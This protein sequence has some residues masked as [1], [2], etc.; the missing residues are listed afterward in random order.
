[1]PYLTKLE[2]VNHVLVALKANEELEEADIDRASNSE[3][4]AFIAV[5]YDKI[6]HKALN[7][8]HWRFATEV[9]DTTVLDDEMMERCQTVLQ[10]ND[11]N[12]GHHIGNVWLVEWY[13]KK[14][15]Y[16]KTGSPNLITIIKDENLWR[17]GINLDIRTV[18]N[19]NEIVK[20]NI[21]AVPQ[22][23]QIPFALAEHIEKELMLALY[24]KITG[25]TDANFYKITKQQSI[26]ALKEAIE[27][28]AAIDKTDGT[29]KAIR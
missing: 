8:R 9:H 18:D 21:I 1:M 3:L 27:A 20:A 10:I 28:D 5:E 25:N 7:V 12:G 17:V 4:G 16:E 14:N 19:K 26:D 2:L 23:T 6:L 24:P 13:K 11:V 15:N 29:M 22:I